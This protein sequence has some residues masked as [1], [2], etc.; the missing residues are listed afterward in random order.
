M[1]AAPA[2]AAPARVGRGA[3]PVGGALISGGGRK[4]EEEEGR[5]RKKRKEGTE[6]NAWRPSDPSDQAANLRSPPYPPLLLPA[7]QLF[8]AS[9]ARLSHRLDKTMR[10]HCGD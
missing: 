9:A 10:P 7:A 4:Q 5:R 3:R 8:N 2:P 1:W 6:R